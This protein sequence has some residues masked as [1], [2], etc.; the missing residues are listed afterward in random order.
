MILGS[1]VLSSFDIE[2]NS[3]NHVDHSQSFDKRFMSMGLRIIG[4]H[5]TDAAE[6][7]AGKEFGTG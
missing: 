6:K 5:I 2:D 7:H 1:S 3:R 4:K